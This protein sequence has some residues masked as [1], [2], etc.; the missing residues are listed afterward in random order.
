MLAVLAVLPIFLFF[1]SSRYT[2]IRF[3]FFFYYRLHSQHRPDPL[4]WNGSAR[5]HKPPTYRQ[6]KDADPK[7]LLLQSI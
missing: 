1:C 3:G 4:R 6:H 2:F 5:L 7:T